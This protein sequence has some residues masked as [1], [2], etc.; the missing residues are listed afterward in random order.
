MVDPECEWYDS[1]GGVGASGWARGGAE[2]SN[3]TLRLWE[4]RRGL[5]DFETMVVRYRETKKGDFGY[6]KGVRSRRQW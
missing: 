5:H 6:E 3:R 2:D 1:L 4:L